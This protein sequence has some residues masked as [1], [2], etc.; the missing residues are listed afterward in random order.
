MRINDGVVAAVVV[1]VSGLGLLYLAVLEG[2]ER[3]RLVAECMA[4]G[5][6]EYQCRAPRGACTTPPPVI[7]S[8]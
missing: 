1:A 3:E 5:H 8:R 2:R 6:K 4:D 7:I